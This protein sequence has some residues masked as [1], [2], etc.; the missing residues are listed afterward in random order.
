M[1]VLANFPMLSQRDGDANASLGEAKAACPRQSTHE[2]VYPAFFGY[3][4]GMQSQ[5]WMGH[6]SLLAIKE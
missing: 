3:K 4:V 6:L 5:C 2:G 1:S